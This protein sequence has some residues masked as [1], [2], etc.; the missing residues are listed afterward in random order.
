MKT[1]SN[2]FFSNLKLCSLSNYK[3]SVGINLLVLQQ[4]IHIWEI[5]RKTLEFLNNSLTLPRK[6]LTLVYF[7]PRGCWTRKCWWEIPTGWSIG[8]EWSQPK[9]W[10]SFPD[11]C[12]IQGSELEILS[13]FNFW[14]WLMRNAISVLKTLFKVS[15]KIFL[16]L[17]KK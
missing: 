8:A 3:I 12:S 4:S 5:N 7:L 17:N 10:F 16:T 15:N 14:I 11:K 9:T 1:V 13:Q 2:K 6:C